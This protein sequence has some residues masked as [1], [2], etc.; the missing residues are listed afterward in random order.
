MRSRIYEGS[1]EHVRLKPALHRLRYDLY[2]Y[3]IDLDELQ[4]LDRGLPCS[5]TTG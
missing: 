4:E 1:V 2:F 3:C 5:A